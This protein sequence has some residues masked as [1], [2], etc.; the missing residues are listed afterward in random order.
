MNLMMLLTMNKD[1]IPK[2]PRYAYAEQQAIDLLIDCCLTKI[3]VSP[4]GICLSIYGK[5]VR[6]R[7]YSSISQKHKKSINEIV[8]LFNTKDGL[9]VTSTPQSKKFLITY[10]DKIST[11]S[12]INFT[13]AH[14]LGHIALGHFEYVNDSTVLSKE[15]YKVLEA[16]ANAFAKELLAPFVVIKSLYMRG[17]AINQ[18]MISDL[19]KI[20]NKAAF[21]ANE[22][23][24]NH[25]NNEIAK[26]RTRELFEKLK[27][28]RSF[29]F[30]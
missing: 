21:Y 19:F 10:N 13:I 3:P 25:P 28:S 30:Y 23:F 20:S 2:T 5:N 14:E 12:R 4:W 27:E 26:Y 15:E 8:N 29:P 17:R 24:H 16:E 11:K 9:T 18:N 1:Q 22:N 6:F 7:T